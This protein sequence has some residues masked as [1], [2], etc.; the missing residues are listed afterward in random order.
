MY[1]LNSEGMGNA[2]YELKKKDLANALVI[3]DLQ[4]VF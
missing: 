4:S 3:G 2:E 1:K